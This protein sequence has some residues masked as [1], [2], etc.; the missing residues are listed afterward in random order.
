MK[1]LAE[2]P[3]NLRTQNAFG[4]HLAWIA[5]SSNQTKTTSTYTI[6]RMAGQEE[7]QASFVACDVVGPAPPFWFINCIDTSTNTNQFLVS[8]AYSI[9]M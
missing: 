4:I 5:L 8:M 7:T 3:V 9:E 2:S 6:R 1:V